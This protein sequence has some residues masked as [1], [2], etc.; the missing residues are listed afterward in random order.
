MKNNEISTEFQL[1]SNDGTLHFTHSVEEVI[2]LISNTSQ[3]W[4]VSYTDSNGLD[5]RW[6]RVHRL[7]DEPIF[8]QNKPMSTLVDISVANIGASQLEIE[9]KFSEKCALQWPELYHHS[10]CQLLRGLPSSSV[11]QPPVEPPVEPQSID[12][13]NEALFYASPHYN[14]GATTRPAEIVKELTELRKSQESD[15]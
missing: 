13:I 7:V 14:G 15:K 4:K 10:F 3:Y 9:E 5:F 2:D 6:E 1:R 11:N 8:W 12:L